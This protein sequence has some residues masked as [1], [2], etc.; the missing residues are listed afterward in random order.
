[1]ELCHLR[2]FV[3]VGE[4]QHY[5][6][7][8]QRLRVALPAL[9]RQIQDLEDEVGFKLFERL[10]RGVKLS[11]AGKLFLEDTR[12]ILQ[13]SRPHRWPEGPA[14]QADLQD[15]QDSGECSIARSPAKQRPEL[16]ARSSSRRLLIELV[17]TSPKASSTSR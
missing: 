3:A 6:R 1:M 5:G 2:Y 17:W 9:S 10:A 13:P 15:H 16:S 11:V 14:A 4:E 12:R 7:A 8:A